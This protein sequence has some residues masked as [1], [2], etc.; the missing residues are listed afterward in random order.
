M[1]CA[2]DFLLFEVDLTVMELVIFIIAI[3]RHRESRF[4]RGKSVRLPCG[5]SWVRVPTE[6]DRKPFADLGNLL[7]TSVSAGLSKDSGSIHLILTID[8]QEQHNNTP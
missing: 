8:S 3:Y 7:T 6:V 4:L 2:K 1:F 5:G